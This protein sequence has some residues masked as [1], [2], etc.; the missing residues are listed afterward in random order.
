MSG[1]KK[2]EEEA[3]ILLPPFTAALCLHDGRAVVFWL[4]CMLPCMG[5]RLSVLVPLDSCSVLLG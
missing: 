3:S 1:W 4:S 5:E 2:G